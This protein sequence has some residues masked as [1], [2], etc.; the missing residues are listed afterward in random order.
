MPI[1]PFL[2]GQ[3]FNPEIIETMSAALVATC[4]APHLKVSDDSATRFAAGK[5]I[6]LAQRGIRDPDEVIE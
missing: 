2:A 6:N 4:D 3:A 5:V 1:T